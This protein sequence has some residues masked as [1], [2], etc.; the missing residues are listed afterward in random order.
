MRKFSLRLNAA[1]NTDYIEK[2]FKRNLQEIKF[3]TKNV[4]DAYFYLPQDWT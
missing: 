2:G 1:K 3:A 4:V